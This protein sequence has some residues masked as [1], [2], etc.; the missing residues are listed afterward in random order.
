LK[1]QFPI[2]FKIVLLIVAA[3]S[4]SLLSYIYVGTQLIVEDKVSYIY[5]Y[6][7]AEVKSASD[8]VESQIQKIVS[9]GRMLG[10]LTRLDA[11]VASAPA[12]GEAAKTVNP[13][14]QALFTQ[15]SQELGLTGALLL[16]PSTPERFKIELELGDGGAAGTEH[17]SFALAQL[18]WSPQAFEKESLLIGAPLAASGA[19]QP[20]RVPVGIRTESA[21]GK[22][23]AFFTLCKLGTSLTQEGGKNYEI[24]LMDPL[25]RTLLSK[26]SSNG[27]LAP[28]DFEAFAKSL[29]QGTFESGVRDWSSSGQE[30]I[31]GYQRL[32]SKKLTV[33]SIISK[34]TAFAAAR[35]LV[36]RSLFL[37][38]SILLLATGVT[39][40]FV[41]TLTRRLREMWHATQ[42]VGEGDFTVRV[43][44]R[45]MSGDEV[46][47]LALSF[48]A[49]ADKITELIQQTAQ[50]ARMEKELETAQAVQNRFFPGRSFDGT[51]IKLSGKYVPASECAGDWWHYAQIGDQLIVVV[52]DVTGHG[53][54]AALVTAAAHSAFSLVIRQMTLNP[55]MGVQLETLVSSL[56]CA[57]YA[58]AAGQSTMTFI[59]SVIDLRTGVMTSSNASHPPLYVYRKPA[60]GGGNPVSHFKPIMDGR[61]PS[62][63]EKSEI[64]V[65]SSSYQL[66]P[67]DKIFWYTDGIIDAR[68]S[69]GKKMNK[70]TFLKLLASSADAAQDSSDR[71][72]DGIMAKTLEFFAQEAERPD[73]I[74]L[75]VANVSAQAAFGPSTI[76]TPQVAVD[77]VTVLPVAA[78]AVVAAPSEPQAAPAASTGTD[79]SIPRPTVRRAS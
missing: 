54:S 35:Q 40:I 51:G 77:N 27:Q 26:P 19:G 38:V 39:L 58:A 34:E 41:R 56:N 45:K 48:N 59:V 25:G 42:K 23:L 10:N 11:G 50:K 17:Y 46:G 47:G 67:G 68:H 52:G 69:D 66:L 1:L 44:M 53:V 57:V 4:V 6:T 62:L 15:Y 29:T 71:M 2:R 7:L 63:G 55:V 28:G 33:V 60:E 72:R 36:T 18:G 20:T 73:D 21:D 70:A 9:V 31:A 43:D 3:L 74:T 78:V 76:E 75:V 5:D 79:P 61:M 14:A 13:A 12:S 32:A 8:K 49:M 64:Q 30:Y 37:G 24:R 22:P 65:E 16:S